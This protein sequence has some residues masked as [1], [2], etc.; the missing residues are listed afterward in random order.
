MNLFIMTLQTNPFYFFA[1]VITV[2]ISI[3]L[4]ELA[5]GWAAIWQGD[6]TPIRTGH[7][8][9]NPVVHMGWYSLIFLVV[10][11]ISW[12]LM[13]VDPSRFRSRRGDALVALAGPAM[14]VLLA[15]IA[16]TGLGLWMRFD[17]I[18]LDDTML[19]LREFLYIFG[20]LNLVLAPFN[21]LPIPPLDGSRILANLD[22]RYAELIHD[23]SKQGVLMLGF[24]LVFFLARYFFMAGHWGAEAYLQLL[25]S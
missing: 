12:G 19:R 1:V 7:M 23:P 17:P 20:V 15:A 13:P 9:L 8:T 11:G 6:D 22:R 24:V 10:V 18:S 5:H 16:L 21:L 3:V 14:N 2:V 4:H 25:A